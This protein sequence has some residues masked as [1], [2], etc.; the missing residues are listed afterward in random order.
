MKKNNLILAALIF[1]T[2]FAC[3]PDEPKSIG[4]SYDLSEG[5]SGSWEISKVEVIDLTL[6]VPETRDISEY[7]LDANNKIGITFNTGDQSYSV[8]NAQAAANP[9]GASGTYQLNDP[10]FPSGMTLFTSNSDTVSLELTNM[11]R[12]IDPFM[13]YKIQKSACDGLYA[14]YQYTFSR[15]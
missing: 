6:P 11:V 15:L 14:T 10:E 2:A 5:I 4:S 13:G 9:F 7:F 12:G 1:V 8:D 3:K